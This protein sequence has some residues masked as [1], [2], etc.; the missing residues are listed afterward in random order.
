MERCPAVE[1]D[2]KRL[3]STD[4]AVDPKLVKQLPYFFPVQEQQKQ[5]KYF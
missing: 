1:I 3:Q 4:G 2:Q 5:D